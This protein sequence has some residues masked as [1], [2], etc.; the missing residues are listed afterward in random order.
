MTLKIT[1]YLKNVKSKIKPITF[2]ISFGYKEEDAL[3]GKVSY[4]PLIYNSEVKV[5]PEHWDSSTGL[6]TNRKDIAEILKLEKVIED[7]FNHLSNQSVDITP[8]TL[9]YELDTILGREAKVVIKKIVICDYIENEIEVNPKRSLNTR[10]QYKN[11][12]NHLLEFEKL[13]TSHHNL[14]LSIHYL[15]F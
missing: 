12:K 7:T 11:L 10:K 2:K 13:K 5:A 8:T 4:K 6:P 3:T 1:T 15:N 9:K 14:K